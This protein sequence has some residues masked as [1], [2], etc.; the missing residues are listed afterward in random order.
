MKV[1]DAKPKP[2]AAG[3]R[4]SVDYAGLAA[5]AVA[6]LL[7]HNLL[8]ATFAFVVVALAAVLLGFVVERRIAPVPLVFSI[9]ALVFGIATLLFHDPRIIKMKTTIIDAALGLGMLGGVALGKSPIKILL[10][11]SLSLSS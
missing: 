2:K 9:A 4:M 11:D 1:P 7:T 3:V 6:Y 5:L 10:G 8:T